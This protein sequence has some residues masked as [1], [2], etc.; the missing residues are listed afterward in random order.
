MNTVISAA[1]VASNFQNW[2]DLVNADL[3]HEYGRD[4]VQPVLHGNPDLKSGRL[5]RLFEEG[6]WIY[7]L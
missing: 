2:E 3:I 1:K 4:E 5:L 7:I 6:T